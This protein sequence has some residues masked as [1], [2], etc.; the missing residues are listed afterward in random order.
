MARLEDA[1]EAFTTGPLKKAAGKDPGSIAPR[2]TS[3]GIPVA[4]VHQPDAAQVSPEALLQNVGF[5]GEYPFT[6]GIHPTMYR[7]KLWTMRQYAGFG[8][9]EESNKR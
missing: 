8:T 6:R 7:S 1:I 9:A 3:S 5:P 2:P 4:A